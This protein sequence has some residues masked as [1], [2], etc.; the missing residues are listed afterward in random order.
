MNGTA[1]RQQR[2]LSRSGRVAVWI[3]P[4][5]IAATALTACTGAADPADQHSSTQSSSPRSNGRVSVS[6]T[7][8]DHVIAAAGRPARFRVAISTPPDETPP[9]RVSL[10]FVSGMDVPGKP[11]YLMLDRRTGSGWEPVRLSTNIDTDPVTTWSE[12]LPVTL[13]PGRATVHDFRFALSG[14]FTQCH[15]SRWT[16]CFQK[17]LASMYLWDEDLKEVVP[18]SEQDVTF[19]LGPQ[20]SPALQIAAPK[21][22]TLGGA[23]K[24]ITVTIDNSTGRAH[25]HTNLRLNIGNSTWRELVPGDV[26]V[27]RLSG[28]TWQRLSLIAAN[29]DK[30]R[31]RRP[32]RGE[33]FPLYVTIG[34][35]LA[36]PAGFKASY[37]LRVTL[38]LGAGNGLGRN[39]EKLAV[40]ADLTNPPRNGLRRMLLA[41]DL[42]EAKVRSATATIQLDDLDDVRRGSIGKPV[43]FT[44]TIENTTGIDYPPLYAVLGDSIARAASEGNL[45]ISYRRAGTQVWTRV[46]DGPSSTDILGFGRPLARIPTPGR[47]NAPSGF[48]QTYEVRLVSSRNRYGSN[49][50][51]QLFAVG[52][53]KPLY[54]DTAAH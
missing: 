50:A 48:K 54:H 53:A 35:R 25:P 42:A 41:T 10:N 20:D 3:L 17:F 8:I 43:H 21:T 22:I 6:V 52:V 12:R 31:A 45:A 24:D 47:V 38:N 49:L 11:T 26:T 28:G 36:V 15:P 5:L 30:A 23:P 16:E 44:I 7:P 27:E 9:Q 19:A 37:H 33:P 46:Q 51:V 1:H 4:G 29:N 18:G 32:H 40:S 2:R 13:T 34:D 39:G 14:T